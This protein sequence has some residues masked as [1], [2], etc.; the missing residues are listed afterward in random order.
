MRMRSAGVLLVLSVLASSAGAV[1]DARFYDMRPPVNWQQR[2]PNAAI[3]AKIDEFQ[4]ELGAGALIHINWD[5]IANQLGSISFDPPLPQPQ[6]ADATKRAWAFLESNPELFGLS[7]QSIEAMTAEIK[8]REPQ[9]DVIRFNQRFGGISFFDQQGFIRVM[10]T[11]AGIA[12]AGGRYAVEAPKQNIPRL[13][14]SDAYGKLRQQLPN[15]WK[16]ANGKPSP[17]DGASGAPTF[18][19]DSRL[20]AQGDET[21]PAR[22]RTLIQ[23]VGMDFTDELIGRLTYY[24]DGT[25]VRLTWEFDMKGTQAGFN[26]PGMNISMIG[27]FEVLIDAQDGHVLYAH[28]DAESAPHG[29]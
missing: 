2:A 21:L 24:L 15:L 1:T 12:S 4:R 28:V 23:H 9:L 27:I 18:E 10:A 3:Q 16:T 25:Q 22:Q 5:N 26:D 19:P 6:A 11:P 8:V 13:S 29:I 17:H 14:V 20:F 7:A